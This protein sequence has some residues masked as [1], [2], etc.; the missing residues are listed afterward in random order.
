MGT[1]QKRTLMKPGDANGVSEVRLHRESAKPGADP[2]R[3][4]KNKTKRRKE[5]N[6]GKGDR[7]RRIGPWQGVPP[8]DKRVKKK[9]VRGRRDL[10]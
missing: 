6:R 7:P 2:G 1:S 4:T 8:M 9:R 10:I 5:K 3:E